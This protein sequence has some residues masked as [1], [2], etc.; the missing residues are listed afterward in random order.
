MTV[1]PAYGDGA[2][3]GSLFMVEACS[4]TEREGGELVSEVMD[5]T[6]STGHLKAPLDDDIVLLLLLWLLINIHGCCY[7]TC[8]CFILG[9]L[10]FALPGLNAL[11][12]HGQRSRHLKEVTVTLIR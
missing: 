8:G 11:F 2:M 12:L 5:P 3:V 6:A 4:E 7:V 1:C 9:H 10:G